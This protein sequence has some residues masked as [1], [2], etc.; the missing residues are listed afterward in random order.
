MCICLYGLHVCICIC[1]YGLHVATKYTSTTCCMHMCIRIWLCVT[2]S[3]DN[4]L[5]TCGKENVFKISRKTTRSAWSRRAKT[6][7]GV[8]HVWSGSM[9]RARAGAYSYVHT[10][11]CRF[12]RVCVCLYYIYV[13]IY[14]CMYIYILTQSY[15][16]TNSTTL[17]HTH[18]LT[19]TH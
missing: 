11:C 2:H 17:L 8:L 6:P 19:S 1:L 15:R 9:I 13:Y 14:T 5:F 12:V 3:S 18:K 16:H 4:V 7:T 10:L